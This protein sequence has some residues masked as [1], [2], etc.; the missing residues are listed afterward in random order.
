MAET[1]CVALIQS[2]GAPK[3]RENLESLAK[4]SYEAALLLLQ[5]G[6]RVEAALL[7]AQEG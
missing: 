5:E 7:G 4:L 2:V 6:Q 3:D 1:M